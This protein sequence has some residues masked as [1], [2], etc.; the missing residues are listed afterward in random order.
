MIGRIGA[1]AAVGAA[2]GLLVLA[3]YSTGLADQLGNGG[4]VLFENSGPGY[5][6]FYMTDQ[7]LA[8]SK[9]MVTTAGPDPLIWTDDY[10]QLRIW[11]GTSLT[12]APLTDL[13]PATIDQGAW[14][15]A[16]GYNIAGWAY[17][18]ADYKT[19]TYQFPT[20]FLNHVKNLVYSSPGARVYR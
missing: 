1:L 2:V 17:G 12:G 3:V 14:V 13:T 16:T 18:S 20:N 4:N 5:N 9:W 7:E 19:A 10:G 8:A 11:A 15:L 6:A